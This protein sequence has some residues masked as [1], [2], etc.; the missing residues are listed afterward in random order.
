MRVEELS[1]EAR[2]WLK[3]KS[4]KWMRKAIAGEWHEGAMAAVRR[5]G[6]SKGIAQRLRISTDR[7]SDVAAREWRR[8]IEKTP[9]EVHEA[10]V[11]GKRP[12]WESGWVT[13]VTA[14]PGGSRGSS[15][16]E[17]YEEGYERYSPEYE[18]VE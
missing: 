15:P 11:R 13:G 6:W 4:G 17:G 14:S 7:V 1:P 12:K 5:R 10:G 8:M 2:E 16:E 3:S 9:E 18:E